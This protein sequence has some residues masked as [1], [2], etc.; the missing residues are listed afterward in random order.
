[1]N[2]AKSLWPALLV[3]GDAIG[4]LWLYFCAPIPGA[5]AAAY[6]YETFH[7]MEWAEQ[8]GPALRK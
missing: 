8:P 4:H 2:P 6:A 5:I 7:K 3:G 1:M